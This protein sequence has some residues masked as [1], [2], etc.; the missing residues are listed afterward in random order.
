MFSVPITRRFGNLGLVSDVT[1]GG[2]RL[3]RSV[4]MPSIRFAGCWMP[5]SRSLLRARDTRCRTTRQD[6]R[7]NAAGKPRMTQCGCSS[8]YRVANY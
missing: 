8:D 7:D 4:R 3:A 5:K 2:A 6:E 1:M